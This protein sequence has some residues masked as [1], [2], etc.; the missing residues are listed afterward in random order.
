MGAQIVDGEE[1]SPEYTKVAEWLVENNDFFR[2][3]HQTPAHLAHKFMNALDLFEFYHE[4]YREAINSEPSLEPVTNEEIPLGFPSEYATM[5]S[6]EKRK[7]ASNRVNKKAYR[8]A[9]ILYPNDS[10]DEIKKHVQEI[11]TSAYSQH[12]FSSKEFI[13]YEG[14]ESIY[15]WLL[16][17]I[18]ASETGKTT[19]E[20]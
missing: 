1:I 14:L 6:E 8:L 2:D 20:I 7:F 9:C 12:G 13:G 10:D 3:W 19:E 4:K 5:L 16:E 17:R 11:Y 15:R 18:A